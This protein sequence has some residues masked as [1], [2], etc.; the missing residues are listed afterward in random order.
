MIRMDP[1]ERYPATRDGHSPRRTIEFH[2][3]LDDAIVSEEVSN[4][5]MD[6]I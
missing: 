4:I 5:S 1:V 2:F 6:Y 3:I